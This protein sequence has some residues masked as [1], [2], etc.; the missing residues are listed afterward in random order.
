MIKY[1]IDIEEYLFYKIPKYHRSLFAQLRAGILPL[2][3][4]TGRYKNVEL[5]ER[6]CTLCDDNLV[7]DEVHFLCCCR[8]YSDLR[9]TL[10]NHAREANPEFDSL[11]MLDKYVYL[12]SDL[13]KDTIAFVYQSVMRRKSALYQ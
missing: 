10:Y 3:I 2:N 8:F 6:L 9:D 7:E 1:G 11:D 12:M 4:E 13:Q 5:S